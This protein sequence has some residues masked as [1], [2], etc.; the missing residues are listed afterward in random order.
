M[1]AG[2]QK[3]CSRGWA[4]AMTDSMILRRK[5][6]SGRR[7]VHLD[8]NDCAPRAWR[9]AF[10]RALLERL[11][12]HLEV[13][14]V[15]E[16]Q[17]KLGELIE[18][19]PERALIALLEGP[20]G[21]TGILALSNGLMNALIEMQTMRQ[22]AKAEPPVRRPTRTDAMMSIDAV[23]S[24]LGDLGEELVH[25]PDVRWCAG[26]C[27]A[28]FVE[29]VSALDLLLEDVPYKLLECSVQIAGTKRTG[30]V[31][32]ALP[33][34]GRG[35][36]PVPRRAVPDD[37]TR[38]AEA[39][40]SRIRETV[41]HVEAPIEGVVGRLRLPLS[42]ILTLATDDLLPIESGGVDQ[43]ALE[44]AGGTR[45]ATCKLGQN[46][47]MRALR[48]RDLEDALRSSFGV[49][50]PVPEA[51]MSQMPA[52]PTRPQLVPNQA[53]PGAAAP[54]ATAPSATAPSA[55]AAE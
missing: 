6:Q 43:V 17:R 34:E 27:Y 35:P 21:V 48:L 18:V 38:A 29:E 11:N 53:T 33:A 12:L 24:A 9:V 40:M 20:E 16:H 14:E 52:P 50:P 3:L 7:V 42:R 32:L 13:A 23:N 10:G 1:W 49:I 5:I 51:E 41:M 54:S 36:R 39:W 28:S 31:M 45:I 19:I 25:S 30:R 44:A 55:T 37:D 22:V 15:R 26:F 46:R 8:T 47:G 4:G 2:Q